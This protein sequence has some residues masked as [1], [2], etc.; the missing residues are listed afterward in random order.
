MIDQS[1]L[2][3]D[4]WRTALFYQVF[5]LS[6]QDS[7]GDGRGD[8]AGLISRLSYLQWLGVDAIWLGP[9]YRTAML[10]SG[11]DIVDFCDIDPMFGTLTEFDALVHAVHARGMKL[12]IDFVPNHTSVE[13][14]WFKQSRSSR[15]NSKRDWYIWRS[16]LP[17]KKLP[18]NWI[19]NTWHPAWEFDGQTGQFYYHRFLPGQPD[20]NFRN[21]DVR[22]AIKD[23]LRFWLDRG[24][25]GFRIDA[26]AD[27]LEDD[28]LR[29]EP[30]E[31]DAAH[32]SPPTWKDHI[33]S[34]DR[35]GTIEVLSEFRSVLDHYPDRV[36]LGEVNV[37]KA[38]FAKYHGLERPALNLPFNFELLNLGEWSAPYVSATIDQY[39]AQ[40]PEGAC[41]NWLLGSHDI[42]RLRQR[43][44]V[45]H[46]RGAALLTFTLPGANF[47][48]YGDEL[49]LDNADIP[50][51][52]MVDPYARFGFSRDPQ[53]CPMPWDRSDNFG[54]STATPY[55]PCVPEA[56][57]RNVESQMNEP[58]S[59]LTF[60]QTLSEFRRDQDVLRHGSF[61]PGPSWGHL[62]QFRRTLDTIS[63]NIALN[64]GPDPISVEG[65]EGEAVLSTSPKRRQGT[66][67]DKLLLPYE[68]LIWKPTDSG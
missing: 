47:I 23:V 19:D 12:I 56:S 61:V 42:P 37:T 21:H 48:Y 24:V 15:V 50:D 52:A 66:I 55:L 65:L 25:D 4:W 8:I 18:S 63:W 14:P 45:N 64:F 34:T 31:D 22:Q 59:L 62:L 5:P 49:G 13:H 57:S 46:L 60:Y 54:F 44:G 30:R 1:E 38:N 53:R 10:D 33:F 7:N 67:K 20:L 17:G 26:A 27:L 35:P 68:G 2:S 58:G 9:V 39:L 28:L 32:D 29:E 6:F 11:Y 40:L 51:E 16:P 43:I 36:L 3:G 41:P